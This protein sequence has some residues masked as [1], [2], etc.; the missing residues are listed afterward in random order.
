MREAHKKEIKI[1]CENA[2]QNE[3]KRGVIGCLLKGRPF[4]QISFQGGR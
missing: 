1:S 3:L 4:P 2:L